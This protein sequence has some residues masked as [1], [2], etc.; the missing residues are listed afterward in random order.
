MCFKIAAVRNHASPT[1]RS[2]AC[3][4]PNARV[5]IGTSSVAPATAARTLW[6]Y[7]EC[8]SPIHI[9]A[10]A[11]SLPSL[12]PGDGIDCSE[13]STAHHLLTTL[14]GYMSLGTA[15][16]ITMRGPRMHM[17]AMIRHVNETHHPGQ[18]DL[19]QEWRVLSIPRTCLNHKA[20]VPVCPCDKHVRGCGDTPHTQSVSQPRSVTIIQISSDV[21]LG[22]CSSDRQ[23]VTAS[24][25]VWV[26]L[27]LN[28]RS[29]DNDCVHSA[30][31]C[32]PPNH[33]SLPSGGTRYDS[34]DIS[35]ALGSNVANG[36]AWCEPHVRVTSRV[37]ASRLAVAVPGT[38]ADRPRPRR[39]SVW[40]PLSKR[41]LSIYRTWALVLIILA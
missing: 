31:A 27:L 39:R 38:L 2:Q 10:G 4:R 12:C 7:A 14:H 13:Y 1:T 3:P 21:S 19:L 41:A 33:R 20:A 40:T 34:R 29:T 22:R 6:T 28:R 36:N 24:G 37:G 5:W 16:W 26:L 18:R 9:I 11:S 30:A 25:P 15:V 23:P 35:A 17:R 8:M 32:H